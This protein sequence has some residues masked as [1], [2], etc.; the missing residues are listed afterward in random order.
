MN[1]VIEVIR[2]L[3]GGGFTG[4]VE[5]NFYCGGITNINKIE[6]MQPPKETTRVYRKIVVSSESVV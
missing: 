6:S 4:R 3:C 1:W 2:G 5:I